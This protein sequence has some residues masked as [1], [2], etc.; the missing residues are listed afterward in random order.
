MKTKNKIGL[1][2]IASLLFAVNVANAQNW[3]TAG[4]ALTGGT[5]STPNEWIGSNNNYD[6]IIKTNNI[7]KMRVLSNGN[8]GIGITTPSYPLDIN[9]ECQIRGLSSGT[10]PASLYFNPS[11][12]GQI[13]QIKANNNGSTGTLDFIYGGVT[14]MSLGQGTNGRVG[15]GTTAPTTKLHLYATDGIGAGMWVQ[16]IEDGSSDGALKLGTGTSGNGSIQ[17]YRVSTGGVDKLILNSAGGNVGIG[18]TTPGA[19]LEVAGQVKI[20]GGTPGAGKILISD[21]NGL[22]SW[23]TV[24]ANG[25]WS[26][27]GNASTVDGTNFIGTTDNIP[28]NIRVNNQKAGRIDQTLLN[29]F[30]GYQAGNANTTGYI[31]TANGHQALYSNTTGYSNT[32]NGYTA[33][34][35]NT[36]GSANVACG[37]TALTLNTTG[38]YNTATG[39]SALAANTTGSYNT[40]VGKALED[41]TT[42]NYNTAVGD[43]ALNLNTT[44]SYNTAVGYYAS[45]VGNNYSNSMFLGNYASYWGGSNTIELGNGN[46]EFLHCQV[47]LTVDSDKR[48]KDDIKENVPGLAFISK[49][50]PVTYHYNI[51]RKDEIFGVKNDH[52]WDGKYDIEKRTMTGFI[53]QEVEQSANQIGYDF[54]GVDK[55]KNDKSIYGLRYAEF[56]VP[57]VKA[58]QEQQ[59]MIDSLKAETA[60]QNAINKSLQQQIDNLISNNSNHSNSINNSNTVNTNIDLNDK[61]VVV[62]EQNIPN[63]FAEQT[64]INYNLP[65]NFARAQIIFIDQSGKFIKAVDLTEKGRGILNVF[66]S[67]LTNGIY[68]Y[69][70]IVDGQTMETKKMMKT[71]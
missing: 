27:T 24:G 43:V 4:S 7:E 38:N 26:T 31:N 19:K 29:T 6:W 22:A 18:T 34:Y 56:V 14:V 59:Q 12:N 33:L 65:D 10:N 67:D 23:S 70:L 16:R 11:V 62:L 35:S 13:A 54:S 46:I 52:N 36:T 17:S 2:T 3:L 53:A 58:V 50:R 15:I 20:T 41:N 5:S 61:N 21:V 57:L 60:N 48:I 68:T 66:A 37:N 39:V 8:V 45:P 1:L 32:A 69:S 25:G 28:F 47:N 44:G 64:I 30:F 55:P 63:P 42:G 51:H 49:L 71:K 40:A 9:G